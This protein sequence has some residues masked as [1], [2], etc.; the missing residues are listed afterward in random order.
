MNTEPFPKDRGPKSSVQCGYP[1]CAASSGGKHFC[2]AHRQQYAT[3]RNAFAA[4][5]K[6]DRPDLL[7]CAFV[8][9]IGSD[10]FEPVKIGLSESPVRRLT[11]LQTCNPFPLRIRQAF[12]ARP[13]EVAFLEWHTHTT[14]MDMGFWVSGEWFDLDSADA[15]AVVAK[16]AE[17]FDVPARSVLDVADS[18]AAMGSVPADFASGGWAKF[19]DMVFGVRAAIL[20]P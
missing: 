20:R 6:T 10:Y 18:W 2:A 17:R 19:R 15:A 1:G 5:D 11:A 12:L 7:N 9:I 3:I 8:Y 4:V 14:L 13:A 16:C